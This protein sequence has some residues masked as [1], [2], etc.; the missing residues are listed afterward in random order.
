MLIFVLETM[1][2]WGL[3]LGIP[4][5]GLLVA[6]YRAY[7]GRV[8]EQQRRIEEIEQLNADLER[9]VEE[10]TSELQG[11]LAQIQ[12]LQTREETL[13]QTLVRVSMGI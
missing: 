7:K 10:R 11:A 12:E 8:D 6:F 5:C 4:P 13:A 2:P 9:L 3:A 1:G